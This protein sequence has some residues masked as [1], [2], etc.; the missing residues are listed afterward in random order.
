MAKLYDHDRQL[1]EG[2]DLIDRLNA[3]LSDDNATVIANA[4]ASLVDIWNRS[5]SV[6]LSLDYS[7]ASKIA[8]IL[9][10]CSEW[11]Q[12]YILEAFT[13]YV[14][15]ES[16]EALFLAERVSALLLHTNAAVVLT[17]IRYAFLIP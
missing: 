13:S 4:L 7:N 17:A 12:T 8:Q 9:P 15:Q 3:L 11:G 6:K 5:D 2:T 10:S 1:I 14:P 16:T